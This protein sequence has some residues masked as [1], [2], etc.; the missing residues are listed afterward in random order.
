MKNRIGLAAALLAA[1]GISGA[2][3]MDRA[4]TS[5]E[6]HD[7]ASAPASPDHKAELPPSTRS[8]KV[9]GTVSAPDRLPV[10]G[11]E[12]IC[13]DDSGRERPVTDPVTLNG[14]EQKLAREGLYSGSI[15]GVSSSAL[16]GALESYK[17]RNA[18]GNG[19]VL[20][21]KTAT[22]LGL[23]WDQAQSQAAV[24]TDAR[25]VGTKMKDGI[26]RAGD[27]LGN[28]VHDA[29]ERVKAAGQDVKK[30]LTK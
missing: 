1:L 20:D 11:S 28:G 18:L 21:H 8:T 30:D 24:D 15:D 6:R 13:R 23:D 26:E 4:P 2:C 16:A 22:R 19:A 7:T 17:G 9:S 27:K 25:S 29:S 5:A 14:L 10:S 12:I 3:N